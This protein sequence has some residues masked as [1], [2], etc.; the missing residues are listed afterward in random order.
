MLHINLNYSGIVYPLRHRHVRYH[1]ITDYYRCP[2][3]GLRYLQFLNIIKEVF[4]YSYNMKATH[5]LSLTWCRHNTINCN[6]VV[7]LN[8]IVLYL[9]GNYFVTYISICLSSIIPSSI[10]TRTLHTVVLTK[11]NLVYYWTEFNW[12]KWNWNMV[13][14]VTNMS[15]NS[16]AFKYNQNIAGEICKIF[17]N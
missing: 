15:S 4:V 9:K 2:I 12:L 7:S 11:R 3:I 6:S 10:L 1:D 13:A 5:Y 17:C 14:I 8:N 16:N